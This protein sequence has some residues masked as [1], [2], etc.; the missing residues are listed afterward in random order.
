MTTCRQRGFSLMETLVCVALIGVLSAV[1]L[2]ATRN[3]QGKGNLARCANNLRQI[4]AAANLYAGEHNGRYPTLPATSSNWDAYTIW[5]NPGGA[6]QWMYFG[7]LVEEGYITD[8]RV[9]YCPTALPG[10]FDY[11]SQWGARVQGNTVNGGF[12]IG[13]LQ[14]V[15]DTEPMPGQIMATGGRNRILMTDNFRAANYSGHP[16]AT[17]NT[18]GQRWVNALFSD[19]HVVCDSSGNRWAH[20]LT[21]SLYDEWERNP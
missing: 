11:A 19:G 8:G 17:K 4:G 2:S 5:N 10:T 12:R 7:K 1:L 16:Y 15:A 20:T 9:F 18:I 6:K 13:Y 3:I 21:G 14:R